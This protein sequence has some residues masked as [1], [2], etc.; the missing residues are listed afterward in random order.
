[1]DDTDEHPQDSL[2]N[3]F[4]SAADLPAAFISSSV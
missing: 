1:M 3:V 2:D 4:C